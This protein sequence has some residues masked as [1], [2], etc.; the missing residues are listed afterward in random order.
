MIK[1]ILVF[2]L[3]VLVIMQF[4]RPKKNSN[5]AAP[6]NNIAVIY[7]MPDDVKHLLEAGCNDCH[8]NNTKY[9]WYAEV[10]PVALWLR[11]H[12]NEGKEEINF[13]EFATY[14]LRRQYRKMEEVIKQVKEGEMPL[15]SYTWVHKEAIFTT[16]QKQS[17]ISWAESIR[18]QM[19]QKY[20]K[21]S[22]I[23]K[24]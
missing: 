6:A 4:F 19:E 11:N 2:L 22:L 24:K 20:P 5:A 17:I 7:A 3:I 1:K 21:D 23:K 12:I 8:S 18:T 10:Q 15:N 9:P 16:A 13:D 14:N